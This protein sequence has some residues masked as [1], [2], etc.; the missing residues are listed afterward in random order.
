VPT[1]RATYT[2]VLK[3]AAADHR[4]APVYRYGFWGKLALVLPCLRQRFRPRRRLLAG[5]FAGEFGYELMQWQA[6]VRGRKP[7]YE[8][9]HVLT[10][11]G[12]D[13]LYEGCTVHHHGFDLRTA[14]YAYGRLNPRASRALARAKAAE[15]GLMDYDIFDA[16]LLCTQ[17]H[18]RLFWRPEFRLFHEPPLNG[19]MRDVAFHFRA[20]RKEGPDQAKNYAPDRAVALVNLCLAH[21]LAVS[22]IGHPDYALCP[23]GASDHRRVDLRETVAAICGVQ[24][25]AGENSGPMHLANLCGKPTLVW[26]ADQARIDYSLRWNPFRVP[27][28]VAANDTPQP[29]PSCVVEALQRSLEAA[30]RMSADF[31]RPLFTMPAQPIAYY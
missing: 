12:R 8:E 1:G 9:V 11:P 2:A 13:Y 18:K 14:G 27:I 16:S 4:N 10:Y 28:Y 7:H 3:P 17:H 29:A 5:P 22:C 15:I 20:V 19:T 26:A 23:P 24:L 30:R 6:F 31:T 21:G 25:V